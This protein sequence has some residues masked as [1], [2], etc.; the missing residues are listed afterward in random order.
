MLDEIVPFSFPFRFAVAFSTSS[1]SA[2]CSSGTR[3]SC[4]STGSLKSSERRIYAGTIRQVNLFSRSHIL[5]MTS[6]HSSADPVSALLDDYWRL[7]GLGEEVELERDYQLTSHPPPHLMPLNIRRIECDIAESKSLDL[8]QV[9]RDLTTFKNC[10][11]QYVMECDKLRNRA[12][13]MEELQT[14]N[15]AL[16]RK[17]VKLSDAVAVLVGKHSIEKRIHDGGSNLK[18]CRTTS[19]VSTDSA[20]DDAKCGRESDECEVM[21]KKLSCLVNEFKRKHNTSLEIV[22][23]EATGRLLREE[24]EL[25]VGEIKEREEDNEGK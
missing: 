6:H 3:T 17:L 9:L 25:P 19:S 8:E 7:L 15:C 14:K 1:S 2:D 10:C 18:L 23:K 16:E 13:K 21:K 24:N 22:V 5:V 4:R 11:A 20:D 12:A